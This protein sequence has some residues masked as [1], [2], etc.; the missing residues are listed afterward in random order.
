MSEKANGKGQRQ[1][2]EDI[3][4]ARNAVSIGTQIQGWV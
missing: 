3:I 2:Q 1:E 4:M